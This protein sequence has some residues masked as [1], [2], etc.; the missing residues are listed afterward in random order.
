MRGEVAWEVFMTISPSYLRPRA[1][2]GQSPYLFPKSLNILAPH[3]A[4]DLGGLARLRAVTCRQYRGV[5]FISVAGM[6]GLPRPV[7]DGTRRHNSPGG[8]SLSLWVSDLSWRCRVSEGAR[9]GERYC[10]VVQPGK[11]FRFHPA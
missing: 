4:G 5:I 6:Y 9:R 1:E 8:F 2:I 11:G 3:I 7:T 10:E